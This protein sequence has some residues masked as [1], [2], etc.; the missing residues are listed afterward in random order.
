MARNRPATAPQLPPTV[1]GTN[2]SWTLLLAAILFLLTRVYILFIL[3]PQITDV[4]NTYFAYAIR[5]YDAHLAPYTEVL[6]VEYPPVAWWIIYIPRLFEPRHITD[7]SQLA[8]TL[9]AYSQV[10]RGLMFLCD[11]GSAALLMLIVKKRRPALLGCVA[12]TY[13]VT[14]A[15]LGHVLY[16]RLD[17]A[18]LL[19]MMAWAFCWLRSLENPGRTIVWS[20]VG[21]AILG[22]SISFKLIPIICVPFLI[23]ADWRGPQR[24]L[25]MT[26]GLAAM[27]L[28][29]GLPFL[30]QYAVSGPGVFAL[31]KYHSERGIQIESLYSTL[32][33]IGSLFGQRVYVVASHSAFDLSGDL[34]KLMTAL[35]SVSMF[36]FLAG[37]WFWAFFQRSRYGHEGG[38]LAACF[39]MIGAVI[40]SKVLSPQYFVWAFPLAL[41]LAIE[42]MPLRHVSVWVLAAMMVIIAVLTTWIFP[43]HYIGFPG[44]PG[45]LP[46]GPME[47]SDLQP[48]PCI[49]LGLR[50]LLYLAIVVWLGV[51]LFRQT[52]RTTATSVRQPASL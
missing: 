30:I 16:D 2:F 29:T 12:L 39:V 45:L 21:Y 20:T 14:T 46:M 47:A 10:F 5:A 18:M 19:L 9:R 42:V 36:V 15:I 28:L 40:L 24:M 32:M 34:S 31:M 26:T 22:L 25:R 51:R 3:E 11:L 44:Q 41:L 38:Y 49:V 52:A 35:S 13:T 1:A 33:M 27:I 37:T 48:G 50:N 7:A 8:P 43:Y 17:V 4:E 6:P 23:L